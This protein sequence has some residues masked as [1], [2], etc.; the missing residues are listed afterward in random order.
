MIRCITPRGALALLLLVPG[1]AVAQQPVAPPRAE[2]PTA[3]L[4]ALAVYPLQVALQGLKVRTAPR[5]TQ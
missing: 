4:Q 5:R 1:L 2:P 3:T